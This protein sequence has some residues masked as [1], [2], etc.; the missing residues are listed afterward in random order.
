M[1]TTKD[2]ENWTQV[3]ISGHGKD[4]EMNR[5]VY[6]NLDGLWIM[7]SDGVWLFEYPNDA[8]AFALKWS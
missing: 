5:W 4:I 1:T 6:E 3:K 8:T 2:Y 7:F